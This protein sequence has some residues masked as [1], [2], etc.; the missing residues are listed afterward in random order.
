[1]TCVQV[2]EAATFFPGGHKEMRAAVQGWEAVEAKTEAMDAFVNVATDMMQLMRL[3]QQWRAADETVGK[4][5]LI[6]AAE[7]KGV[8]CFV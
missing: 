7:I 1:V 4:E 8:W 2:H 6:V 5:M 3:Q